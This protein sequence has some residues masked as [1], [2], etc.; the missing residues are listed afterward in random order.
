MRK[1]KNNKQHYSTYFSEMAI[2]DKIKA[3]AGKTG[4]VVVYYALILYYLMLDKAIPAKSKMILVA[5]LGYFILPADLIAD[6][7]PGL[8]FTDDIAFLSYA[9]T[10]VVDFIT[11][12]IKEKA[13]KKMDGKQVLGEDVIVVRDNDTEELSE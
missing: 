12:E 13:R 10:T 9:M 1:P 8:G 7:I 3:L 5:A 2:M 4:T 6:I 11:P